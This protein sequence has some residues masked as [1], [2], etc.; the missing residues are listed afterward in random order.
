MNFWEGDFARTIYFQWEIWK[1]DRGAYENLII[2]IWKTRASEWDLK[3]GY[4]EPLG[5]LYAQALYV[6]TYG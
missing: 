2:V 3:R 4:C 5:E 1:C 6:N